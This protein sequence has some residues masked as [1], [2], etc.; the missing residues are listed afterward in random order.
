MSNIPQTSLFWDNVLGSDPANLLELANVLEE[1]NI[2]I[3]IQELYR[4]IFLDR[5]QGRRAVGEVDI[6]CL[7]QVQDVVRLFLRRPSRFM[8]YRAEISI[9]VMKT[10]RGAESQ[11]HTHYA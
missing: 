2:Q 3:K 8:V 11:N 5:V 9:A 6:L 10:R 7:G 1:I 4:K